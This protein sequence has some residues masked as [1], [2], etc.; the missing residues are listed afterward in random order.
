MKIL[1][2]FLTFRCILEPGKHRKQEI[3]NFYDIKQESLTTFTSR[4]H[5]SLKSQ[6]ILMPEV[7]KILRI[8]LK[9][10]LEN[11][12]RIVYLI[13]T[14]GGLLLRLFSFR[15][16]VRDFS[17][18]PF[19]N[20]VEFCSTSSSTFCRRSSVSIDAL[21]EIFLKKSRP[22]SHNNYCIPVLP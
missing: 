1:K 3:Y 17:T 13:G 21:V 22:I 18:S 12:F 5:F 8:C 11:L 6:K 2:I 9:K 10:N 15:F 14:G 4:K 20:D 7:T 19:D 16:S